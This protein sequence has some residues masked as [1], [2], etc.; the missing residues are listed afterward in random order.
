MI[1]YSPLTYTQWKESTLTNSANRVRKTKRL[2]PRGFPLGIED[3]QLTGQL[4]LTQKV[5]DISGFSE[6][7]HKKILLVYYFY[8]GLLRV[9][10]TMSNLG[11]RWPL[12]LSVSE[13]VKGLAGNRND[14]TMRMMG[15]TF[16]IPRNIFAS[17]VGSNAPKKLGMTTAPYRRIKV[18]SVV[19]CD[20][21][22]D[23]KFENLAIGWAFEHDH[24][25]ILGVDPRQIFPGATLVITSQKGL[26]DAD[27]WGQDSNQLTSMQ[28]TN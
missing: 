1:L 5:V 21:Q 13:S 7:S 26:S 16:K 11:E 15:K 9:Q 14:K 2:E 28:V 20:T 18:K 10:I 17:L 23:V 12:G 22:I 19:H 24:L 3:S 6:H 4:C 25:T 27:I 8:C